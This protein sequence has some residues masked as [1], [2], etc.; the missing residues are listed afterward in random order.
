MGCQETAIF[1]PTKKKHVLFVLNIILLLS[2]EPVGNEGLK[3][4]MASQSCLMSH[5]FIGVCKRRLYLFQMMP[6]K[7]L[8]ET[9]NLTANPKAH[10]SPRRLPPTPPVLLMPRGADKAIASGVIEDFHLSR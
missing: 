10:K 5:A 9:A 8:M 6:N 4:A 1:L 3:E 2:V 7:A